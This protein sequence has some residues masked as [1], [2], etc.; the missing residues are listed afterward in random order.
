MIMNKISTTNYCG[1]ELTV[2]GTWEQ[3][4]FLAKEVAE[5]IEH[6]NVSMMLS[7]VDDEEKELIQI[8]T[9]NN[10]YS[11]WFLS[12]DGLY[13]VL[14]QSRKPIAKKWKKEV[15]RL[16]KEQRKKEKDFFFTGVRK[17]SAKTHHNYHQLVSEKTAMNLDMFIYSL[18]SLELTPNELH[19]KQDH[20]LL[21]NESIIFYDKV[22][23]F[24][25]ETI[26]LYQ[27]YG[28]EIHLPE[29]FEIIANRFFRTAKEVHAHREKFTKILVKRP[30]ENGFGE[31]YVEIYVLKN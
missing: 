16:L 25:Y 30:V 24:T 28:K 17:E 4:Y 26:Q 7:K 1:K 27:A 18:V 21:N 12:E 20:Y 9:L 2:Y 5:W 15:K 22:M 31:E 11:A 8:G 10:A 6:S 19:C 23:N 3:P 29:L 14:M 13:E